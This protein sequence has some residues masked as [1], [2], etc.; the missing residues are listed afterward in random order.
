MSTT[1]F[2]LIPAFV[3][4]LMLT[5]PAAAQTPEMVLQSGEEIVV[6][7]ASDQLVLRP[8]D[9]THLG[10][11]CSQKQTAPTETPVLPTS[12]PPTGTPTP[13]DTLTAVPPTAVP[14][15][16]TP[17]A[18]P[19]APFVGAPL[20]P[21]HD[22]HQWH[23]LWDAARGCHYDHSHNDDPALGNAVFGP[24]TGQT[25]SYPWS[26]SAMENTHKHAGYKYAVRTNLPCDSNRIWEARGQLHCIK[27]LRIQYHAVAGLMDYLARFHSYYAE[28]QVCQ[29]P[30]FTQCGIVRV[31]G[32]YDTGILE[33]PYKTVR[34]V[35][36]AATLDFGNGMVMSF[37]ADAAE[38]NGQSV[39]DEP[40]LAA[41]SSAD[42]NYYR[43][44]APSPNLQ[45]EVWS[46][47]D[48]SGRYGHNPYARFAFR[49]FDSMQVVNPKDPTQII[50]ICP[51]NAQGVIP[52][53]YN[54]SIHAMNE[55][56]T[57]IPTSFDS[58]R[59]GFA[60]YRGYTDRYGNLAQ[61]CTAP[62]LDCVPFSLAHVPVGVGAFQDPGNG[63]NAAQ[64][65][66]VSPTG[67]RWI[68]FPN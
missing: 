27:A 2:I 3:V 43:N 10:V 53:A 26:T 31:G 14:P 39:N 50:D 8:V 57:N 60:D 4:L 66:D 23:S 42:L 49:I 48:F 5:G 63:G 54:G 17:A 40:Y 22:P 62:A 55:A 7:C 24:V 20:C 41:S 15:T 18:G 21:S 67:V 59:D 34:V 28:I 29:Y 35:R 6:A 44:N 51:A 16:P 12:V 13:T 64:E 61:G 9:A 52:C 32:W 45:M 11:A 65:Y 19:I 47:D 1:K 56:A 68:A 46:M 37:P 33:V 25:I 38:L 36:P 58:D 30:T